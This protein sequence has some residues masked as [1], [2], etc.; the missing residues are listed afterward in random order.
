[1]NHVYNNEQIQQL[2]YLNQIERSMINQ[3]NNTHQNQPHGQT[4][5]SPNCFSKNLISSNLLSPIDHTQNN[6][7]NQKVVNQGQSSE[8]LPNN[9]FLFNH[10]IQENDLI[11][12]RKVQLNFTNSN[13]LNRKQR[14]EV[15]NQELESMGQLMKV[16]LLKQVYT[17]ANNTLEHS[18]SKIQFQMPSMASVFGGFMTSAPIHEISTCG[19]RTHE[20]QS[21]DMG[22]IPQESLSELLAP[23]VEKGFSVSVQK[24][25]RRLVEVLQTKRTLEIVIK[26]HKKAFKGDNVQNF[27]GSK[28]RGISKNGNSWQILVMVNRK[29]KY[30]G[31]LP[32][33]DQ[34][35]KFYDK[36]AIQYQGHKAKTNYSYSKNQIIQILKMGPLL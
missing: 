36:V 14:G 23:E 11:I 10:C 6:M 3:N 31:T 16:K 25:R 21:Y 17:Q 7:Q 2:V 19:S 1:M 29:K 32:T 13:S 18:N 30:L 33:E 34:A 28:F 9:Q 20:E 8:A 26:P 4:F 35:A 27:R 22:E 15:S 24:K 12:E 5:S